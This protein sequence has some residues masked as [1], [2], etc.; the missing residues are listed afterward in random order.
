MGVRG[1]FGV[2][3]S[4]VWIIYQMAG[5][6]GT[7][8]GTRLRIHLGMDMYRL[9]TISPSIPQGAEPSIPQVAGASKFHQKLEECHDLHR[10]K[11]NKLYKNEMHKLT[12]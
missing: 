5:P 8:F 9:K 2:K 6:I 1:V 3:N 11:L 10:K 4:K 12:S 7:T